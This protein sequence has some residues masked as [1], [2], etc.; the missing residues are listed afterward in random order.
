MKQLLVFIVSLWTTCLLQAQVTVAEPD[1]QTLYFDSIVKSTLPR[2]S[3]VGIIVYDL[4]AGKTCYEYQSAMLSRP[5]SNMKLLTA[6][7]AL[8]LPGRDEPFRTELWMEGELKA[9]TLQGNIYV[10]GGFDPEFDEEALAL[11]TDSI[12]GLGIKVI[13]GHLFGDVSMKDSLYWGSGW[14]WDD[15]PEA[16]Q[17][18]LSPLMLNKGAVQIKATAGNAGEKA[19]LEVTPAST[20]YTVENQTVSKQGKAGPFKVTRDWLVNGNHIQVS[21]NVPRS[22]TASINVYRSEDFFLHTM[23]DQLSMRDI[24][25]TQGY[26]YA[27]LPNNSILLLTFTTP[28]QEVLNQMM[29]ESDNLNAEAM[30]FR[31]AAQSTGQ[32]HL[33]AKDGT[34]VIQN[35]ITRL[36]LK[37]EDYR[38]ADGCGLSNYDYISPELLIAFLRYAYNN[39]QIYQRLNESLPIAGV[40]GTLQTRMRR[41][42]PAYRNV[43]AKT[44]TVTGVSCLSG[45]LKS[46]NGHDIAF[47]IMN[48]NSLSAQA[49]RN[50]QDKFC[51]ELINTSF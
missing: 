3:N 43:R 16:F 18:Y 17:P 25:V 21:G 27:A 39:K 1:V 47:S 14:M 2:G 45:Y 42:S 40:D 7:T 4:T 13:E 12:A 26:D 50:F 32:K 6:I 15:N 9:D 19:S 44:G 33:T 20:Y 51:E 29:K 41:G 22:N 46:N 30:L 8:S 36:G 10:V 24:S 38:L 11:F 37:K 5:A 34:E 48:Q 35:L 31:I 49:A 23:L 28:M